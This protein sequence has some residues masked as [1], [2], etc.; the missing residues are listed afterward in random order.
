[1]IRTLHHL[2]DP[3]LALSQVRQALRADA[4]FILEFA[5]KQ[6]L[7]SILRYALRRQTWNPFTPEPVEFAALNFDFH[8]AAVR[9]WLKVTGFAIERQLTVSHFRIGFLKRV[10][11]LGL[12]VKMDALAQLTGDLWQLS[13]SVFVRSR[14]TSV[15]ALPASAS[16]DEIAFF[17]CPACGHAP[18]P[19]TPPELVCPAC[20]RRYPVIDGI[21]D[22][23]I[24]QGEKSAA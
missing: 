17:C 15:G 4:A 10:F 3:R 23:R 5:N 11:P 21:Y 22:M 2:V 20:A 8:P 12:L 18:L 9:A 7:K 14:A 24:D 1:M 16:L 13:P 19:D 6:N